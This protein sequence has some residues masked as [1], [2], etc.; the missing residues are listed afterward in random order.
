MDFILGF[1]FFF[2][3]SYTSPF[4]GEGLQVD[5]G[6]RDG[7]S[8]FACVSIASFP[9]ALS[10]FG[11]QCVHNLLLLL[12]LLRR[13]SSNGSAHEDLGVG[14]KWQDIFPQAADAI[15]GGL[16]VR[17]VPE[18]GVPDLGLYVVPSLHPSRSRLLQCRMPTWRAGEK[19][20][21]SGQMACPSSR[22]FRSHK[23]TILW[24]SWIQHDY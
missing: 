16:F 6:D 7:A 20:P 18:D 12:L 5:A 15:D 9:V 22:L 8:V 23:D 3:L 24:G 11:Q 21:I 19:A 13:H 4:Y 17:R 1:L 10:R 2:V 14:E